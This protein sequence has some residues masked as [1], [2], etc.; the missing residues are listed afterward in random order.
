[1][2]KI[3][4]T[5]FDIQR[6]S[7]VDGPGIRTTVFFK[8]CNLHCAWCHNPE[9]HHPAHEMMF[10]Q[11]RCTNCGRCKQACPHA[12]GACDL[13]GRCVISCPNGAR[14]ICGRAYT[15][16]DV[17][18]EIV[19]DRRFYETSGGGVTCSG[20]ECMLQIDFLEALLAA[21]KQRGIHTA[22]DT[23]GHVAFEHFERIMPYTDLFLYDVKH[24][25]SQVHKQYTGVGNER[26]LKN[27]KRLLEAKKAVWIRI[28]VIP[29]VNDTIVHMQRIREFLRQCPHPERIE[30]LPYHAMGEHKYKAIGKAP[31]HFATPSAEAIDE[32]RTIL[33]L[34]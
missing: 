28:P 5:L 26:I 19:K 21:C 20:G 18:G 6:N 32:L 9:S 33:E 34:C 24:I 30:L 7:Y 11:N 16:D 3:T 2:N 10:Y 12:L 15:V 23:A 17:I 27:L 25:D 22:V 13:C 31:R 1:M 14:E 29:T 8:G 4:A